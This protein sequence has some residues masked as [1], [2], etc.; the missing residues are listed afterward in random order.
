MFKLFRGKRGK[1]RGKIFTF[2]PFKQINYDSII[3]HQEGK[4]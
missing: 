1:I 4:G 3:S 2:V